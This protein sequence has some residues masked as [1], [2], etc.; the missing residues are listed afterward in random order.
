VLIA[1][2]LK[3]SGGA[4]PLFVWV[5]EETAEYSRCVPPFVFRQALVGDG[6]GRRKWWGQRG[7]VVTWCLVVV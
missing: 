6:D 5:R 2:R 4:V 3:W 7:N 1:E